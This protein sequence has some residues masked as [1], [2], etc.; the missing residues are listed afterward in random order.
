MVFAMKYT[1][2]SEFPNVLVASKRETEASVVERVCNAINYW[3]KTRVF[4]R[5]NCSYRENFRFPARDAL[6]FPVKKAD[7]LIT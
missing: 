4:P 1:R 3:T 2:G 6:I 5:N 7:K